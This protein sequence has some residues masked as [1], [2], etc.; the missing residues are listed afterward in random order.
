MVKRLT[1]LY[2]PGTEVAIFL[3]G[4]AWFAG[5]VVRHDPPGV[6]VRTHNGRFWFVTNR[7]RI[8]LLDEAD[9]A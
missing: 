6:W 7:R 1:E 3:G 8:R 5:V 2:P 9:D 4:Q